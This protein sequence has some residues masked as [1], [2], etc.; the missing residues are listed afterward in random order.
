M[1]GGGWRGAEE[2]N[3]G[4]KGKKRGAKARIPGAQPPAQ[5]AATR[6]PGERLALVTSSGNKDGHRSGKSAAEMIESASESWAC[7]LTGAVS[8]RPG[9]KALICSLS[10]S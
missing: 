10:E 7:A 5:S 8:M 1:E 3:E 2:L 4:G 9:N 6:A